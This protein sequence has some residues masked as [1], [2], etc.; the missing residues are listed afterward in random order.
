M[1]QAILLLWG[2]ESGDFN[3]WGDES[4]NLILWGDEESGEADTGTDRG[5]YGPGRKRY[6][7]QIQAGISS[8]E[9]SVN[10]AYTPWPPLD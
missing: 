8:E 1:T 2:D 9:Q 10:T 7:A 6:K 5:D 3:L 4:G